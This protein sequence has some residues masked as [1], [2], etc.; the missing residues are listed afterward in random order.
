MTEK[1]RMPGKDMSYVY[2]LLDMERESTEREKKEEK[3]TDSVSCTF[4][5]SRHYVISGPQG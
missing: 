2:A 1:H 3:S 4:L 5:F